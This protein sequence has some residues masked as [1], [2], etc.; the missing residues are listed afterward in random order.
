MKLLV[1]LVSLAVLIGCAAK[2]PELSYHMA[3]DFPIYAPSK[4]DQVMGG[5][6][7]DS[8]NDPKASHHMTYWLVSD[9]KPEDVAA[10]YREKMKTLP[11]AKEVPADEKYDQAL[12]QF[13]CGPTSEKEKVEGYEVIVEKPEEGEETTFR[14]TETLVPGL[15]YPD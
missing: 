10:F 13:R 15:K 6:S 9:N 5:Q 11:D 12:L 4:I 8:M 14:V 1:S 2:P 7:A 3:K